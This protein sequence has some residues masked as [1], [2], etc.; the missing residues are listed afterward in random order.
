MIP[1]QGKDINVYN[2][3]IVELKLY[4]L[5]MFSNHNSRQWV[6][7]VDCNVSIMNPLNH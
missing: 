6:V 4:N 1:F 3:F 7:Y 2:N 5:H